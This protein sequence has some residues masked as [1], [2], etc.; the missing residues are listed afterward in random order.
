[1]PAAR[2]AVNKRN[3]KNKRH[4]SKHRKAGRRKPTNP[5]AGP[6]LKPGISSLDRLTWPPDVVL[7]LATVLLLTGAVLRLLYLGEI[8]AGLW[9]DEAS[10]GYEA[11]ALLHHGID[12]NGYAWPVHFVSWGNGQNALYAYLSLP[13][14]AA[15][16]LTVFSTRLL[17]ALAGAASLLLFW[18]VAARTQ[19]APWS[20]RGVPGAYF[21]LLAL[22]L[23]ILC[24][25]HLM[26]SRWALESN[27]LP[28]V[29]LL[30]VY[31][32]TRP[33]NDR[34]GVQAAGVFVLS[35]SVYAYG[36]AYFFAP[37]FLALVFVWLRLQ[38][39]LPLRHFL[40]LSTLS[41]LIVLPILLVLA[42]NF[43]DWEAIRAG[44]SMPKYTGEARYEQKSTLF[45]GRFRSHFLDQLLFPLK[46]LTTSDPVPTRH[47]NKMANFSVLFPFAIVPLAVGFG[48]TIYRAVIRRECGVPLLM[49]LWLVA[50]FAT[51]SIVIAK[52][53][54]VNIVW[55]PI[56]YFTA[57][58]VFYAC[59]RWRALLALA[60]AAYLIYGGWF[61]HTYFTHY[62]DR[63]EAGIVP[64]DRLDFLD[65]QPAIASAVEH[66]GPGDKIYIGHWVRYAY[67]YVLFHTKHPPQNYRNTRTIANPN[68]PFQI[69]TSFDRFIFDP[70]RIHEADHL[71]LRTSGQRILLH[72]N[73]GAV[74]DA[75]AIAKC[76]RE[77]HGHFVV[78]LCD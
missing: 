40:L 22:L 18:R 17:Q 19:P 30:A 8:P 61:A 78:L 45:G 38:G 28:F 67:I 33:D 2:I 65:L 76:A 12:R 16:D 44:I 58:G 24:P 50:A 73:E 46:L 39:K 1:M 3:K 77:Q 71:I 60:A 47:F 31:F 49:A 62:N 32:L 74:L 63:H 51:S 55:L 21:A 7:V 23:L 27:L 56:V 36:P 72:G 14:I 37:L 75:A 42:V 59:R 10:I 57:L 11:W 5:D 4:K 6:Q 9:P 66:A 20:P 68:V 15:L 35:L 70:E 53:N 25:W 64:P 34:L 26:L 41:L 48:A 29:V 13:I 54:R 69:I 43:F 52:I